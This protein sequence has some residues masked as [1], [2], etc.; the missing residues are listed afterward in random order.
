MQDQDAAVGGLVPALLV[1]GVGVVVALAAPAALWFCSVGAL[2]PVRGVVPA[3][4]REP[5]AGREPPAGR[6]PSESRPE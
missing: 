3:V 4:D 2:L 6:Q 5:L 1:G